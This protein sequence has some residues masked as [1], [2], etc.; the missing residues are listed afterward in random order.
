VL[1][2]VQVAFGG[3]GAWAFA[4]SAFLS[5][6]QTPALM[7]GFSRIFADWFLGFVHHFHLHC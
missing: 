4:A 5:R 3:A 2:G 7:G 1:E 6:G